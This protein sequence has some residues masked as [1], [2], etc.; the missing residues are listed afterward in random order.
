MRENKEVQDMDTEKVLALVKNILKD[1]KEEFITKQTKLNEVLKENP[2]P[3]D[4]L[5]KGYRQGVLDTLSVLG[6]L[7]NQ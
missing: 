6:F 4:S 1:K 3:K 2:T 7:K 5:E